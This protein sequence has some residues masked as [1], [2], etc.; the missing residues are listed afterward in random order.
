MPIVTTVSILPD[1]VPS[2]EVGVPDG[3]GSES[4]VRSVLKN[5]GDVATAEVKS[6]T[7]L[8]NCKLKRED[9]PWDKRFNELV[10]YREKNGNCD[11][12]QKQG[13]LGRWVMTQRTSYKKGKLSPECA[14]KLE[15]IGFNRDLK[16]KS[17]VAKW[18][19][20]YDELVA[21]REKNG[22]CNVPQKQ[23]ALG[24]WVNNQRAKYKK[25]K[26]SPESTAQL[27][28]IGFN[29]GTHRN[30]P[31]AV[32]W[33]ERY[34]E[35]VTY[36][37]KNGDFNV[38]QKQGALGIWVNN[39]RTKY[40][41][42]KL[43]PGRASLLEAIGFNWGIDSAQWEERYDELVT[44]RE[45]NGN[46]NVPRKQGALGIWV[47]NQRTAHS[48]GK[49]SQVR[50]SQLESIRFKWGTAERWEER[51]DELVDYK[52]KNGNCNVPV[53]QGALGKWVSSQRTSYSKGNLSQMRTSQLRASDSNG[54]QL[55]GGRRDLT[56][57]L[58]TKRRMATATCPESRV[59]LER[60]L[61]VNVHP[62]VRENYRSYAP[63]NSRALGL[64]GT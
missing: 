1:E 14:S 55:S 51:F 61:A 15:G 12:P 11:V 16:N 5:A 30:K 52:E 9:T 36:R 54:V 22:N 4:G 8:G 48:K 3:S 34:D 62:T 35:L 56:S 24:I 28:A 41:K 6:R 27:D 46:C 57:W 18:E 23:G 39:Q 64:C 43:S 47:N 26:L 10:A 45:K 44:Y 38:P 19:K 50:T 31:D 25:G 13:S 59:H 7:K 21:Y 33:K 29:W 60:G 53:K 42:G 37:E 32:K 20:K 63:H 40:K 58:N 17:D 49:L 2:S